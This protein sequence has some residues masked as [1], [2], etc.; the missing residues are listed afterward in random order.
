MK[1]I[2]TIAGVALLTASMLVLSSCEKEPDIPEGFSSFS[3]TWGISTDKTPAMNGQYG[4]YIRFLEGNGFEYYYLGDPTYTF[5]RGGYVINGKTVSLI[6]KG[7]R[8]FDVMEN[9]PRYTLDYFYQESADMSKLTIVELGTDRMIMKN[10]SGKYYFHKVDALKGWNDEFSAPEVPLFEENLIARW[11]Q[12]DF[13]ISAQGGPSWWYFYEPDKN[14]ITLYDY[15]FVGECPFW[16]NRILDNQINA[17]I[18]NQSELVDVDP[19]NCSWL[20]SNDSVWLSCTEY[21][22]YT[23]GDNG[24][25]TEVHVV[26]PEEPIIIPFIIQVLTND[27]LILYNTETSVFHAFHKHADSA[28]AAPERKQTKPTE[29][30]K[31]VIRHESH[32]WL[33]ELN[34]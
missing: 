11:D 14:G 21:V 12:L 7:M 8:R 29:P 17:K 26:T 33:K 23:P 27:Y 20:M 3:G 22:A 18:L 5:H 31:E 6:Y 4:E 16:A 34:Y 32:E 2:L 1:K 30:A 15:G 10:G 25:K 19:A 13:Y 9:I 24:N 28:A